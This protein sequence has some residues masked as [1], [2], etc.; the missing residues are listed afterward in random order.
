MAKKKSSGK[1]TVKAKRPARKKSIRRAFM[2]ADADPSQPDDN[3][4]T[5]LPG[6]SRSRGRRV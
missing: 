2:A 4:A 1:K 3:P 6:E 5:P